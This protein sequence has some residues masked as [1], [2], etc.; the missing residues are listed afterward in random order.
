M[1]SKSSSSQTELFSVPK[2]NNLTNNISE[3]CLSE[4]STQKN[5]TGIGNNQWHIDLTS[6]LRDTKSAPLVSRSSD[7][8]E[9]EFDMPFIDCELNAAESNEILYE[10]KMDISEV[11]KRNHRLNK[12][13]SKFGK[14]L[15]LKYKR[16]GN[17][18]FDIQDPYKQK[19]RKFCFESPSPD[20]VILTNL[21][22][23]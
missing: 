22:K 9:E 2:L 5:K 3:M 18:S 1:P 19:C 21:K 7:H 20:D 8:V 4:S 12:K 11:L 23:K 10:C 15:C 6:A 13:V 17:W 16:T 14:I